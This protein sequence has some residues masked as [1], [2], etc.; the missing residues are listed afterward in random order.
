MWGA[1]TRKNPNKSTSSPKEEGL[2]G[3]P[4]SVVG[5][6][7]LLFPCGNGRRREV[8]GGVRGPPRP[9]QDAEIGGPLP[10]LAPPPPRAL[11][12]LRRRHPPRPRLRPPP[13]LPPWR[14]SLRMRS[15]PLSCL[16]L[17]IIRSPTGFLLDFV[18]S[19]DHSRHCF[20]FGYSWSFF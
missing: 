12:R 7:C 10:V 8:A 6:R 15:A 11:H 19:F 4:W 5:G 9:H 1:Y 18:L 20:S 3:G 13:L 16:V 17:A 14:P 2:T